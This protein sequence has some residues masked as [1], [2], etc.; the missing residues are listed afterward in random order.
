MKLILKFTEVECMMLENISIYILVT[1]LV[2]GPEMLKKA[3][4][5]EQITGR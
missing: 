2:L 4:N 1:N 3:W 5:T